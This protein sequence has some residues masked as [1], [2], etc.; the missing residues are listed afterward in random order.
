LFCLKGVLRAHLFIND[1]ILSQLIGKD[2]NEIWEI[3]NPMGVLVNELKKQGIDPTK[4]Q[5]RY[6]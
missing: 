1:F 4:L 6:I 5:P 2:I 3:R